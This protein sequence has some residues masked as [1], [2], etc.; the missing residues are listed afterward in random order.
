MAEPHTFLG[1][2]DIYVRMLRPSS[3]TLRRFWTPSRLSRMAALLPFI[4]IFSRR[5]G[6]LKGGDA[7][8]DSSA[9]ST[10]GAPAER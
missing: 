10:L 7:R 6:A 1:C 3:N 4:S 5:C 8:P 2:I 9:Q